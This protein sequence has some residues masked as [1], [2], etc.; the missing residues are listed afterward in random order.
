MKSSSRLVAIVCMQYEFPS[1]D[2]GQ[3][4]VERI[5]NYFV[6]IL[7]NCFQLLLLKLYN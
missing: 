7:Q 3:Q 5:S 4:K 6:A 2:I 1:I